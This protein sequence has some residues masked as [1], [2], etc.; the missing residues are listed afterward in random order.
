MTDAAYRKAVA[1]FQC[2]AALRHALP[3]TR[4]HRLNLLV[5]N[6]A[7]STGPGSV[8][9][10]VDTLLQKASPPLADRVRIDIQSGR[11]FLVLHPFSAGQHDPARNANACAVRRRDANDSNSPRSASVTSNSGTRRGI[12]KTPE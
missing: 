4:D 8:S 6:G 1:D 2:V 11:S 9:Q 7:G 10:T 12:A 3:G 5:A